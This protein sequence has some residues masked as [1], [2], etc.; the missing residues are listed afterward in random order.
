MSSDGTAG[1]AD[2]PETASAAGGTDPAL[3]PT[4]ARI[5]LVTGAMAAGGG[6][7]ARAEDGRVVFV[8]HALPGERVVAEVTAVTTSFLRADAVEVIDASA[9]RVAP[10]CPHAGPGRCGGCD[11]QHVSLPAQRRLKA[12]LVAEQL[13]RVAGIDRRVEVEE[14]AGA[15]DGLGWRTRANFAVDRSGRIGF[16][17]HRSHDIEPVEHCPIVTAGSG[18]GRGRYR[19]LAGGAPGRGHRLT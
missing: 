4:G 13:R 10:P 12:E 16:H 7:V 1:G 5:E 11:W 9:D 14:V 2:R 19:R 3:G 15:A 8:R 18:S 6:C 17:R